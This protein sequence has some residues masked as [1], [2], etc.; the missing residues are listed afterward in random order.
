MKESGG[1]NPAFMGKQSV[2]RRIRELTHNPITNAFFIKAFAS[3][4]IL[5]T[6][7][8]I[9]QSLSTMEELRSEK[10]MSL[11]D[12]QWSL[13]LTAFLLC[14]QITTQLLRLHKFDSHKEEKELIIIVC[15]DRINSYLIA[16]HFGAVI[17]INGN[18]PPVIE[19]PLQLSA[20]PRSRKPAVVAV[21]F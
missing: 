19:R 7:G 18:C 5:R 20:A 13:S 12:C 3:L 1:R 14:L 8:Q 9:S 2:I 6:S 17:L 4:T 16:R 15:S 21:Y 11:R 10:I